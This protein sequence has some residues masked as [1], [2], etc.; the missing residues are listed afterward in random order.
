MA[1]LAGHL[2]G[3]GPPWTA[4]AK[5]PG[6]DAPA[7]LFGSLEPGEFGLG[8][9]RAE[10]EWLIREEWARTADDILWRRTKRGLSASPEQVAALTR[11]L[12]SPAAATPAPAGRTVDR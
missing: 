7:G 10:I 11:F 9:G 5:L 12:A 1:R 8:L 4:R 2:P 6:D 3:I